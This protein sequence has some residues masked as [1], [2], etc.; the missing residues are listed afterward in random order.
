MYV[1]SFLAN[2]LRR[3]RFKGDFDFVTVCHVVGS[4]LNRRLNEKV[5]GYGFLR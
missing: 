3:Y 5:Y 1:A 4:G 2:M